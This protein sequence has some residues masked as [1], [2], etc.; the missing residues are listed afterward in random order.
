MPNKKPNKGHK[1]VDNSEEKKAAASDRIDKRI[2]IL[3][4][5]VSKREANF[6][7]M[8][9]LPKKLT[10]FT[11]NNDWIVGDVDL[12]SMTFGRGTYYQKWNRDRFEKRLNSIFERIKKPKKVDDEVQMLNKKVAQ[13]E[14]E[15]IN[16]M[17]TNLLLD[18]KLNREIKL[19]KQQLE[20]SQ[21]TSRRLQELLS[22]K[23]VIVPFNKP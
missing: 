14:L 5:I 21:N 17:E 6:V 1:N 12:K 10:E 3:E 23:A 18:R 2:S 13:L 20:A 19:L 22:Q 11:D 7:S 16:L 9:G 15:N 4:E 8:E